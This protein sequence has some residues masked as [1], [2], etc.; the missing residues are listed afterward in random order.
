MYDRVIRNV[1][2][3]WIPWSYLG[4]FTWRSFMTSSRYYHIVYIFSSHGQA[5]VRFKLHQTQRELEMQPSAGSKVNN[6]ISPEPIGAHQ[7]LSIPSEFFM[8][9]W[10]LP[11]ED[12]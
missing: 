10:L 3:V 6:A 11:R 7:F 5:A 8:E 12:A 2:V 1:V 9:L 4:A